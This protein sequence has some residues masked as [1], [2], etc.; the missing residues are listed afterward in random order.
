MPGMTAAANKVELVATLDADGVTAGAQQATAAV[1]QIGAAGQRTGQDWQRLATEYQRGS[2][3]IV[4]AIERVSS[5]LATQAPRNQ[6]QHRQEEQSHR[7]STNGIIAS[8]QRKLA[9]MEAGTAGSARYYQALQRIQSENAD[10]PG[11]LARL[12]Q[13]EATH[14]ST[15]RD[16]G[17]SAGQTAQAMRMLPA[18]ITDV[19]TSLVSGMPVWMVAIQQGGQI[20]DSFGG[21]GPAA[22][23]ITGAINPMVAVLGGAASV[24]AVL[25][26]AAL[27]GRQQI[28]ALHAEL[29]LSGHASGA[30]VTSLRQ[31]QGAIAQATGGYGLAHQ[32]AVQMAGSGRIAADVMAEVGTAAVGMAQVTGQALDSI[33]GEF[34]KLGKSPLEASV[35]LNEQYHYLTAAVYEQIRAL[36]EQ[37]RTE[38]AAALAQRT[39]AQAVNDR[40][41]DVKAELNALGQTWNWLGERAAAAWARMQ[42]AGKSPTL[43]AQLEAAIEEANRLAAQSAGGRTLNSWLPDWMPRLGAQV[44]EQQ[45][46]QANLIESL[47]RQIDERDRKARQ[48]AADAAANAAYIA[49]DQAWQAR[50]RQLRSWRETLADETRKIQEEGQRLGKSDAEITAQIQAVTERLTPKS[51]QA[52]ATPTDNEAARI[53]ARVQAE[54]QLLQ[55]LRERG[56]QAVTLTEGER[57]VLQLQAQLAGT[58]DGRTRATKELALQQAQQLA[59]LQRQTQAEREAIKTAEARDKAIKAN[60]LSLAAY[61][62]TLDQTLVTSEAA[63][64]RDVSSA[65]LASGQR[66]YT[67][68][69]AGIDDKYTSELRKLLQDRDRAL[70][71]GVLS[72]DQIEADYQQRL[73]A[74]QNYIASERALYDAR[75]AALRAGEA[76][77]TN[78][79]SQAIAQY[80]E[81][82]QNKAGQM[83]EAFTGL[84]DDLT[85][86][87]VDLAFDSDASFGDIAESFARMLVE[88]E[89]RAAAS[90]LMQASGSGGGLLGALVNTG[91]SFFTGATSSATGSQYSLSSGT[92]GLGLKFNALGDVYEAPSL[93]RYRNQVHHSPQFFAFAQGGVFAEAGSEAIMPL[94]RTPSGHLGVRAIGAAAAAPTVEV[95]IQVNNHSSARVDVQRQ[96]QQ[97]PDGRQLERFVIGIVDEQ[98]ANAGSSTSRLISQRWGM[99]RRA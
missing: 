44:G 1:E 15:M 42:N 55:R 78:G 76:D 18:Q 85:G 63:A 86:A 8:I 67:S 41:A 65:W 34:E 79:A 80:V 98:L 27:S 12:S 64:R 5:Q 95:S 48:E 16:M 37:G 92:S 93:S 71:A 82:S 81:D 32:A 57:L 17:V 97:M 13:A 83:R 11:W 90:T 9:A 75:W 59:A 30:T 61:Q 89:V 50:A 77:W 38:E 14:A 19:T 36:E 52:R 94:Q 60:A 20:K 72:S 25:G 62:R 40:V 91:L 49:A 47:Q 56:S 39:Y 46:A 68:G 21:I 22:R 29:V 3:A 51:Q 58:L 84:F 69:L 66:D 45:L 10:L 35:A 24:M 96:S 4:S 7:E 23:A 43:E 99:S 2:A 31:V 73:A 74:L 70:S 28:E 26:A 33:I 87:V 6:R 53:R 88:M 54:E